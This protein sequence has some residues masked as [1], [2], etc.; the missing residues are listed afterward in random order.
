MRKLEKSTIMGN[1]TKPFL[2]KA[3]DTGIVSARES[4]EVYSVR[5]T[6]SRAGLLLETDL[7]VCLVY[8]SSAWY[9]PIVDICIE[10]TETNPSN[11]MYIVVEPD[12]SDGFELYI[13]Q[14][15]NR[16][17]AVQKKFGGVTVYEHVTRQQGQSKSVTRK[18]RRAAADATRKS[19]TEG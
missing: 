10:L 11:P 13:D 16:I 5:E 9:E 7:F 8:K 12:E 14:D 17:W 18:S 2:Q 3:Y 4:H 1:G 6:K 15:E 19:N